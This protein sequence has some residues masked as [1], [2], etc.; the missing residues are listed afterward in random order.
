MPPPWDAQRRRESGGSLPLDE[1]S[2]VYFA[3]LTAAM[4]NPWG[5]VPLQSV[6]RWGRV[7]GMASGRARGMARHL[8][9][10]MQPMPRGR[11]RCKRWRRELMPHAV[12][13]YTIFDD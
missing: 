13:V 1:G 9:G 11:F 6:R 12:K 7:R 2:A 8:P 5:R 4:A 10:G 3:A